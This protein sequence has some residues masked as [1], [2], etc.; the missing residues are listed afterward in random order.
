MNSQKTVSTKLTAKQFVKMK[1]VGS[2]YGH[3]K[4]GDYIPV[5]SQDLENWLNEYRFNKPYK[6]TPYA[7]LL[8][9]LVFFP[10]LVIAIVG[11]AA[12][13]CKLM[14]NFIKYGGESIAY[15]QK[16]SPKSILDCYNKLEE[17]GK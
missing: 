7:I 2:G 3:L 1:M 12:F 9:I 4:E 15:T 10:F 5:T 16:T 17:N 11:N 8:R 6:K 14:H 13:T